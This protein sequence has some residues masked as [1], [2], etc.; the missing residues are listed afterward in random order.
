MLDGKQMNS[1][2]AENTPPISAMRAGT[3]AWTAEPWNGRKTKISRQM[4]IRKPA[5]GPAPPMPGMESNVGNCLDSVQE[6]PAQTE[7][8]EHEDGSERGRLFVKVLGVRDLS[9]P[10]P[11]SEPSS[12]SLQTRFS[13]NRNAR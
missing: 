5:G 12:T 6:N 13:A 9:L 8:E 7:I 11:Q 10:L 2:N 3:P 1:D 4:S